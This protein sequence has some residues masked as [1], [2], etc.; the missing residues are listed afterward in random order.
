MTNLSIQKRAVLMYSDEKL[1][2]YDLF[3]KSLIEN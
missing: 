2:F 1:L 3:I